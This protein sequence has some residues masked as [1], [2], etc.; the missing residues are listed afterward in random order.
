MAIITNDIYKAIEVLLK[1]DIIGFP[2]ETVYGLAGNIFSEKAIQKIYAVKQRP[3]FNPLIVHLHSIH[4]LPIV[5]KNIPD[6]AFDVAE[7]CWPGPLTL[8]LEKQEHISFSV[9]GGKKTVAVRIPHHPMALDLLQK[10]NHPL[11]AP[12]ANPFKAVSPTTAQQVFTYFKNDIP[13]ILEGG[14][15]EKGVESTIIGFQ[16]HRPVLFRHGA[17]PI[18]SIEKITGTLQINNL[19]DHNPE[20]PG[21][22][23]KHYSPKT[24]LLHTENI[25][26][27]IEKNNQRKIG[28][29]SFEEKFMP[30]NVQHQII[31]S[32][33]RDFEEAARNLYTAL[34]K[35]DNYN[36]D[37][38]IAEKLP[39]E[40]LGR[41]INDRLQR[42][43]YK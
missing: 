9:T 4:Q 41:T 39:D 20:A 24:E 8:I 37:I 32:K 33:N 21:M 34:L 36:L 11:V 15:C 19:N 16:N 28:V 17:V 3:S 18:E 30:Q 22:L 7:K 12:S 31:L 40:L 38:I 1:D 35:M 26:A 2:T 42:A 43:S 13:L 25:Y 29:I 10:F 5:A 14:A 23:L 6:L 27:A